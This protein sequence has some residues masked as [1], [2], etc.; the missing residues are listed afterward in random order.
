M[1]IL[2]GHVSPETAYVV[3]DYPYGYKLRCKIRYWIEYRSKMGF[4]F[5]SQ[6]TNP[7]AIGEVWNKA[8]AGTYYRFGMCMYINKETGHVEHTALSE[9]CDAKQAKEW[10]EKYYEGVD[11]SEG[12]LLLKKFVAA[13]LAYEANRTDN[14]SLDVGIKE[15]LQAFIR[16]T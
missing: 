6:T 9:Y 5:M 14:D 10:L 8:K 15:A 13:K 2:K 1:Q 11:Y 7:K 4:R 12:K 3:N 16:E